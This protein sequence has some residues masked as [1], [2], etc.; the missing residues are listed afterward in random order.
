MQNIHYLPD[1][2]RAA[3]KVGSRMP[4]DEVLLKSITTG[5]KS[6]LRTF[7]GRYNVRVY[8]FAAHITG[9]ATVAEDVVSE[10][11]LEVWRQ[12]HKFGGRSRVSTW[13]LAIARHKALS[14]IKRRKEVQLDDDSA[15]AMLDPADDPEIIVHRRKRSE[16]I[17]KCLKQLSPDHQEVINLVYYH[18]NSISEVAQ[19]VGI[20]AGTVKTRM[21]YARKCLAK[22]LKAAGLHEV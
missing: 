10:V 16:F 22:F 15:A 1:F 4:S 21:F 17:Q 6:A 19:I 8:R 12:A 20:P 18:E 14:A 2:P 7:Y 13:L 5:D 11:F 9:D 3:A